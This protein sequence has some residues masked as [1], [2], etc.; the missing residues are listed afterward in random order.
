MLKVLVRKQL[1]EVFRNYFYDSKKNKPRS[2]IKVILYFILFGFLMIGVLGGIFTYLSLSL[3]SPLVEAG[4]GWLYYLILGSVA[5]LLGAFGSV[6]N[7]YAGLYRAKDNDLLLSMP[8]PVRTIMASRLWN[9]YLLGVLYSG[10]VLLPAVIV[11]WAVAGFSGKTVL[12]AASLCVFVSLFIL[13]L[14]CALGWVIAKI[15]VKLKNKSFAS[16]AAAIVFIAA[17]YFFYFRAQ[18][19]INEV[20]L[21]AA[22]YGADIRQNAG[23]LYHF[24]RMGEGSAVS[25]ILALGAIAAVCAIV[26]RV[27]SRSFLALATTG[28]AA[29]KAKYREARAEAR[30]PFRALLGKELGRF[31][32]SANYM[33]NC[34]LGILFLFACGA[35]MIFRGAYV[36]ELLNEVF[37]A[38]SGS[39]AAIFLCAICM[40]G[41]MN[42]MATPSVS[43]EG[44]N[45]WLMQALPVE[46]RLVLLAK[47]ALQLLLSGVPTLFCAVCAIVV[48]RLTAVQAFLFTLVLLGY[49]LFSAASGLALGVRMANL[50]WTSEL[51]PI[52]QSVSVLLVILISWAYSVVIGGAY[53]AVGYKLGLSLYLLLAAALTLAGACA[54]LRWLQGEG[55]RRFSEL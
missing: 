43:L 49:V 11:Y 14:S 37:S 28:E 7:T 19:L 15:S 16:V 25:A 53:L 45:L 29:K 5:I 1:T 2:R 50:T 34:G 51:V 35:V 18:E 24:G 12:G 32:S 46:P 42:D 23:I 20:L 4:L 33:L 30:T 9:V 6:F 47:L 48:L 8:I 54:E 38:R 10:V 55:S 26:W 22:S 3:C 31:T 39:T 40:V 52:K 36:R 17:Y 44:R 21:N 13:V 27:L 41:S